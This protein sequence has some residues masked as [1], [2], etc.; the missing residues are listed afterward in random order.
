M[1]FL[2]ITTDEQLAAFCS[3]LRAARDIAFD[4]EFV[5]EHTYR[6]ELCLIQV[7]AGG[8]LA[9]IDPLA[10]PFLPFLG[11]MARRRGRRMAR[12]ART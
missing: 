12:L 8:Q 10:V 1:S 5:S 11:R 2:H 3:T 7:A 4:T 9:V 6:S